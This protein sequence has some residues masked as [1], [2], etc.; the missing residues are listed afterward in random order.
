MNGGEAD[1]MRRI[2]PY[3]VIATPTG[4]APTLDVLGV[5]FPAWL[6]STVAGVVGSYATVLMLGRHPATRGLADSGLL[7]VSLVVG[8]A[9]AFWWVCFSGF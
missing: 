2:L 6:V 9:L 3:L 4:C 7:F 8:I 1:S 5:Y